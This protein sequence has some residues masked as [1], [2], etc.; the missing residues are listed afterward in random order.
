MDK[1][2]LRFFEFASEVFQSTAPL[3]EQPN[4]I[5]TVKELIM[6]S[7]R[8]GAGFYRKNFWDFTK[9]EFQEIM[10]S[11]RMDMFDTLLYLHILIKDCPNNQNLQLL[12]MKAHGFMVFLGG[13][14]DNR[15]AV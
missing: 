13:V 4:L 5:D 2:Q 7:S 11:A 14:V 6:A 9:E 10:S 15:V 1:I 12:E 3:V 8:M